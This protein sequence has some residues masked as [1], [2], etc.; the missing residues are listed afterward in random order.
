M[1]IVGKSAA[2]RPVGEVLTI[3]PVDL[4]APYR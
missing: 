1:A 3:F 2:A 4:L